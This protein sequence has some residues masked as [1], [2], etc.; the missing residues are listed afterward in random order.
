MSST[1]P[2]VHWVTCSLFVLKNKF[3]ISKV[4]QLMYM[5]IAG[6]MAEMQM[7]EKMVEMQMA[8]KMVESIVNCLKQ[9]ALDL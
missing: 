3:A 9:P 7:A 2:F 1:V 5:Q 6:K 4:V 8:E